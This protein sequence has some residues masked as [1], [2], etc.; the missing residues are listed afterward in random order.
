MFGFPSR[1]L[2]WFGVGVLLLTAGAVIADIGGNT[3]LGI[4][5]AAIALGVLIVI[6]DLPSYLPA[7]FEVSTNRT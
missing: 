6:T 4:G 3:V 2:Q 5:L 7:A 1:V